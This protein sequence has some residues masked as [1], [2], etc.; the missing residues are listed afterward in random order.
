VKV[1]KNQAYELT[2]NAM[3]GHQQIA[4]ESTGYEY[5]E[6]GCRALVRDD[7]PGVHEVLH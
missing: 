2:V 7:L 6:S 5:L 4:I 3:A 1:S